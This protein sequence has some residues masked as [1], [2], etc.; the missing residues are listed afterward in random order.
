MIGLA[1]V[2]AGCA[3]KAAPKAMPGWAV[4]IA[5]GIAIQLPVDLKV[6]DLSSGDVEEI[7]KR[8]SEQFAKSPEMQ[9]LIESLMSSGSMK[10]VGMMPN[11]SSQLMPNSF[12]LVV[13]PANS[14]ASAVKMVEP[15]R[16]KMKAAALPGTLTVELRDYKVGQAAYFEFDTASGL[17]THSQITYI[18]VKDLKQFAFTFSCPISEK[19]KWSQVAETAIKSLQIGS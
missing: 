18:F 17:T 14:N 15:N 10:L 6:S 8:N 5:A 1:A 16:V 9:K 13:Q 12:N 11:P 19:A 2:F 3:P 7:R 4:T